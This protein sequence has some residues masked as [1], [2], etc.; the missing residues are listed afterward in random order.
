MGWVGYSGVKHVDGGVELNELERLANLVELALN[1]A[2]LAEQ[3]GNY[4]YFFMFE[5]LVVEL[6]EVGNLEIVLDALKGY[7]K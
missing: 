6:Q 1:E 7:M 3:E 5:D 2:K 4:G